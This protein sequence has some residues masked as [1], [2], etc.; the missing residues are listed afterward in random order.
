M[1]RLRPLIA[2]AA[3]VG[4]GLLPGMPVATSTAAEGAWVPTLPATS[5]F[6]NLSAFPDGTAYA[7]VG[8]VTSDMSS[9]LVPG[10]PVKGPDSIGYFKST[11]FGRTWQ[12]MP[13]PGLQG[14]GGTSN[15]YVRFSTPKIGYATY[16]GATDIPIGVRG[17]AGRAYCLRFSSTF[18]T[19]DGGAHW[20]PICEPHIADGRAVFNAASP[21][22]VTRDGR[23]VLLAGAEPTGP[24]LYIADECHPPI[25][26]VNFS[27]NGGESWTRGRLPSTYGSGWNIKA[28]D[29]RTAVLLAYHW[30]YEN[31]DD[32]CGAAWGGSNAVFL[33]TDG[34]K[35][36]RNVY[37]CKAQPICTTVAFVTAKRIIVGKTDGS[38]AVTNDGGRTW[39]D[40][41]QLSDPVNE[42]KYAADPDT[43]WIH[44]AQGFGFSDALHGYA[45]TRGAG[46]WRT[47]DGGRTWTQELSHEC[48]FYPW[49]VGE[50]ASGTPDRSIT[51][52]PGTFSARQ[53][54]AAVTPRCHPDPG[55]VATFSPEDIAV[56][57]GGLALHL[58]GTITRR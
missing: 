46:T 42:A 2:A 20:T 19:V 17:S 54:S 6:D 29:T 47:A 3:L 32:P 14:R 39:N 1:R 36:Y 51:G 58:D 48:V 8:I 33:T 30:E 31:P 28:Y 55:N 4:A 41:P 56:E 23:T 22:A 16:N 35:T 40:G 11:D 45:S 34:G 50:N 7:T 5:G 26:V 52:G 38:T 15:L 13:P 44:W 24:R 18:R 57:T 53:P 43:R 9:A 10:A 37:Q 49:G 27:T 21:L 25:S 12:P